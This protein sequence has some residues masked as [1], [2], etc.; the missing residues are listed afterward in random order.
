MAIDYTKKPQQ[1]TPQ[2]GTPAPVS[3]SKV[4]LTKNAPAVSL[5][6]GGSGTGMIRVNLNW[7]AQ[8]AGGI[9][10]D[11][12]ALYESTDGQKGVV[13]ALGNS[14]GNLYAPPYVFLDGD[15]RSGTNTAG[16]NLWINLDHAY[17]IRRVLVFAY[18]YEGAASFDYAQGVVTVF[19]AAGP[20]I[21]V[22]LDDPAG[23][24]RF[25]AIAMLYN[26]GNDL[27]INR[28]IRYFQG[29]HSEMDRAYSWG[30][31]WKQARK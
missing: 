13:Q 22:R 27:A 19:P 16:E 9:D 3:L 26:S 6:K 18:I 20:Q 4:T 1:P 28:E 25:C 24:A 14:F 7:H 15:D 11:L 17:S 29:G 31:R 2:Q 5:T 8:A 23:G 10:L 30:M 12:G 21:E